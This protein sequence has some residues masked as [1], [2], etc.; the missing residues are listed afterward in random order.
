MFVMRSVVHHFAYEF[1]W[2]VAEN[3]ASTGIDQEH[4]ALSV[5]RRL[6]IPFSISNPFEHFG[7]VRSLN[8]STCCGDI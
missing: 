3:C 1:V 4:M 8:E 6:A 5:V 7:Q 2:R